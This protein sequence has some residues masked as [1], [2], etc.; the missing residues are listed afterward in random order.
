MIYFVR[1]GDKVK[2]RDYNE[3]YN[4][5]LG[6]LDEP[7]SC[8]G[9]EDAEKIARYFESADI[10]S[11]F[12]SQYKRA[13]ETA[14][15]MARQK[16]ISITVDSRVNEIN[17]GDIR[18]MSDEEIAA[19]YPK[20][21]SEIMSRSCDFRYPGGESG[22]DVKKRQDSFLN[23][24]AHEKGDIMVVSHDGYIRLL[25]CSVL[26]LPVYKRYRF[27]TDMGGISAVFFDEEEK[28]WRIA[29]FNQLLP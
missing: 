19:K 29:A 3:H 24:L 28:E 23:D 11:I 20:L 7:L 12:V 22:K 16:G 27:V 14:E 9:R 17:N 21:W 26:G 18:N 2:S 13:Y 6:I 10:K 5:S 25:M 1:H 4:E 15:P 8:K